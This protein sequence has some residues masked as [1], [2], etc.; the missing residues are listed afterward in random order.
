MAESIKFDNSEL[1]NATYIVRSA[2]ADSFMRDIDSAPRIKDDGDTLVGFRIVPKRIIINGILSGSSA[3]DLQTKMD[4]LKK[5]FAGKQK[6]LDITPNGGTLRRYVATCE[7]LDMNDRDFYHINHCPYTAEFLAL[8]GVGKATATTEILNSTLTSNLSNT[9]TLTVGSADQKPIFSFTF[10][11]AGSVAGVKIRNYNTSDD[12]DDSMII[13]SS[14]VNGDVLLINSDTKIVTKN[15]TEI[16]YYGKFPRFIVGDN[17]IAITFSQIEIEKN[18]YVSAAGST[19]IYDNFWLGQ[20]FH[21]K[22]T[23]ATYRSI[24]LKLSKQGSPPNALVVTIEGD[25]NGAP[26]GSPV[27][28]FTIPAASVGS[29]DHITTDNASNFTLNGNSRYWIVLKTTGGDGSNY[30]TAYDSSVNDDYANGNLAESTDSG[31]NWT[32]VYTEDLIFHLYFGGKGSGYS[33]PTV[34]NYYPRYL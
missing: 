6:N 25:S 31:V 20:S 32:N 23:D 8:E 10:T 22:H 24:K 5:L 34:I 7:K 21:V 26:D 4:T 33:I 14:F 27:A 12:F 15:G 1:V 13:T 19:G 16:N 28:T 9:T 2:K 29:P 17:T 18:A 30:Y 11:T 3:S